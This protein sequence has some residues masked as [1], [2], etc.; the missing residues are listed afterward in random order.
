V[1][2]GASDERLIAAPTHDQTFSRCAPAPAIRTLR[3]TNDDPGGTTMSQ[4]PNVTTVNR[5][6]EAIV[7]EDKDT[8]AGLFTND[9][10]LHLRGPYDRAGDHEGVSGLVETIGSIFEATGGDVQLDQQFAVGTDGWAAEWEHATL[11][12]NG[13]TLESDNAFIYRFDGDRIAEMWMFLGVAPE[14]VGSFFD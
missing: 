2:G 9:F 12:R 11:G 1:P 13:K 6:T 14:R 5:M 8:L 4:H 3:T 10:V 7:A